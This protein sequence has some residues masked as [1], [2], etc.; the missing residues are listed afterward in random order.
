M[1]SISIVHEKM[2]QSFKLRRSKLYNAA[3]S[4]LLGGVA[5]VFLA[6]PLGGPWGPCGPGS[7]TGALML[8]GGMLAVGSGVVLTLTSLLRKGYSSVKSR[9]DQPAEQG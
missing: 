7:I 6:I 5:F 2:A 1:S 4:L 9:L 8:F 3:I